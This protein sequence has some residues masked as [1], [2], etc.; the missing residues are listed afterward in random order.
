MPHKHK[1]KID[2]QGKKTC[3]NEDVK[4]KKK[5]KKAMKKPHK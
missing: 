4:F 2:T 3:R 5:I 1:K